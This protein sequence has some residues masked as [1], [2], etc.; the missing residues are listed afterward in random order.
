MLPSRPKIVFSTTTPVPVGDGGGTRTELNVNKYNAAAIQA[1]STHV[2]SGQVIINDLH[3]DIISRCGANY[4]KTG[5]CELQVP[6]GVHFE[7][8]GRQYCALSVAHKLLQ[9]QFGMNRHV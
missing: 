4:S 6:N 5:R 9:V 8:E 7:F 2:K 3:G 1:L